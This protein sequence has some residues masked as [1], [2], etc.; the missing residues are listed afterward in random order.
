[1][2][3]VKNCRT[4]EKLR[5]IRMSTLVGL[6]R[7]KKQTNSKGS[8]WIDFLGFYNSWKIKKIETM[9]KEPQSQVISF[10]LH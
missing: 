1:M 2:E 5:V 9:S 10:V 4:S 8:S 3:I 6:E 7:S